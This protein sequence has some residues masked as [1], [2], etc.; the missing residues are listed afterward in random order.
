MRVFFCNKNITEEDHCCC[1]Y[2][3]YYFSIPIGI[4]LLL[5]PL[6]LLLIPLS[7]LFLLLILLL[8]PL[9]IFALLLLI[10]SSNMILIQSLYIKPKWLS[11][12]YHHVDSASPPSQHKPSPAPSTCPLHPLP[13]SV[14]V[15]STLWLI[16]PCMDPIDPPPPRLAPA[17]PQL[18]IPVVA[19][20]TLGCECGYWLIGVVWWRTHAVM[21]LFTSWGLGAVGTFFYGK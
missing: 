6:S 5:P 3:Y 7:L 16:P 12:N 21:L 20:L 15:Y 1:Y 18:D 2:Y 19:T 14:C 11:A 10:R 9:L 13:F 17:G 8:L 4:M